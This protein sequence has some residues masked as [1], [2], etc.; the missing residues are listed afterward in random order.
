MI[1]NHKITAVFSKF[2]LLSVALFSA[3]GCT[4][5]Y[6]EMSAGIS[7]NWNKMWDDSDE[8]PEE[9]YNQKRRPVDNPS[10]EG[11][12]PT[13]VQGSDPTIAPRWRPDG[14]RIDE[15]TE[16]N[17]EEAP[18]LQSLDIANEAYAGEVAP[19]EVSEGDAQAPVALMESDDA[20]IDAPET[21]GSYESLT[22][23]VERDLE[24]EDAPSLKNVPEP[25]QI[26]D[27][28]KLR[29]REHERRKVLEVLYQ[30]AEQDNKE[31]VEPLLTETVS[32]AA[33]QPVETRQIVQKL[34]PVAFENEEMVPVDLSPSAGG[35]PI[36]MMENAPGADQTT[37]ENTQEVDSYHP[38]YA[39]LT[40]E[41]EP[42]GA[43]IRAEQQP[44]GYNSSDKVKAIEPV[45]SD[46]APSASPEELDETSTAPPTVQLQ[47]RNEASHSDAFWWRKNSRPYQQ[48]DISDTNA[49]PESR[50]RERRQ[51]H[52]FK[53]TFPSEDSIYN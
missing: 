28:N 40:A 49:L 24:Q 47:P 45:E 22:H 9:Y 50:Y 31:L 18:L 4:S 35:N 46:L 6:D 41:E 7:Y 38:S 36:P 19:M 27:W 52:Q 25:L 12:N 48:R 33:V 10:E 26:V 13:G 2:L 1:L 43:G 20:P 53:E 14:N 16:N 3:T 30:K 23:S 11:K 42:A 44:M 29:Q 5:F 39:P 34:E 21:F 15:R 37:I 8:L 32:T 17:L 51:Q